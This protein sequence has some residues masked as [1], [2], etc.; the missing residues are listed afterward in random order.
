MDAGEKRELELDL[1]NPT[2]VNAALRSLFIPGWGQYFNGQKAKGASLL[3][4][5]AASLT[6]TIVLRSRAQH[7]LADYHAKGLPNDPLY[8][9]YEKQHQQSVILQGAAVGFWL[10]SIVDAYLQ[11]RVMPAEDEGLPGKHGPSFS[12]AP[13]GMAAAWRF[14][15]ENP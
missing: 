10:F 8:D 15:G 11:A 5:T 3:L 2:P 6:G 13:D 9:K 7:T 4:A 14:G 1:S 12:F